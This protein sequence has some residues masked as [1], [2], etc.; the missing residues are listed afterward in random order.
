MC[1]ALT[2]NIYCHFN[3]WADI[4]EILPHFLLLGVMRDNTLENNIPELNLYL[5]GKCDPLDPCPS[6]DCTSFGIFNR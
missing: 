6:C 5:E 1:V 2:C 4:E 3:G